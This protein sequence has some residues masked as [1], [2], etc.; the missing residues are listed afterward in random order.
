MTTLITCAHC[1]GSLGR[2][3]RFCAQCGAELLSCTNCGESLLPSD[4]SCPECGTVVEPIAVDDSFAFQTDSE[5]PWNDMVERLRRATLGE[6]EI[7][8]ELGRGGMAAVFLAH[9]ISLARKVAIKVMSPGLLLDDGMIDRFR[10]EA[11]TIAH[12]HH[13]H[14]VSVYSVRQEG[15]LYFFVMQYVEG[16]S[17]EQVIHQGGKLPLP[18][19]RSV[20][21]QVGS[22]LTYAH[23]SRV[24]HRDIKPANILIDGDGN[25]VVTDFGIAKAAESPSRTLTGALVGTPAYMSPEQCRGTE[26]S[27]AS[28]QYSL[29]AVA[30]EML[31]G[32][33]P[34]SGSTF[35]VMQAH[36]ERPPIPLRVLA[37]DC[38]PEL[39]SVIL[40]M[41]AKDPADRFPRIVDA[42]AA[43]GAVPLAEDDPLRAEL[44]RLAAAAGPATHAADTTP[45][46]AVG[47]S[48]PSSAGNASTDS[49]VGGITI[50]PPPLGLEVGDTFA[51]VATVR[52]SHGTVLPPNAVTWSC[53]SPDVLRFEQGGGEAIAVGAGSTLLT[54]ACKDVRAVIR[55]DVALPTADEIVITPIDHAVGVGDEIRLETLVRDKRGQ[56]VTRTV[57]WQSDDSTTAAVD[58]DGNLVALAPGLARITATLDHARASAVIPVVPARVAAIHVAGR[59][60]T[61]AAGR[62]FDVVAT[63]V[64]RWGSPLPGRRVRWSSSDARVAVATAEGRVRAVHPGSVVL[65]A[66]CEGVSESVRVSVGDALA[67]EPAGTAEPA[68]AEPRRIKLRSVRRRR[69]EK[70]LVIALGGVLAGAALWYRSQTRPERAPLDST[71]TVSAAVPEHAASADT[72]R[73]DTV[74]PAVVVSA[75]APLHPRRRP[76]APLPPPAPPESATVS[77]APSDSVAVADSA[78]SP[79]LVSDTIPP[80]RSEEVTEPNRGP[81]PM[82]SGASSPVIVEPEHPPVADPVHERERAEAR[83]LAGVEQCYA[84]VQSKD[85][86]RIA[87]LYK[88]DTRDDKD[89]L[90]KLTRILRTREWSAE[91][92]KRADGLRQLGLETAAMEFS[93]RLSWKDAFGG[94]LSSQ[95]VF[96][97]EFSRSGDRW[98]MA[99]CRIIGSPRL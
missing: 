54:A 20:M 94:H 59:P 63:P 13:P 92:G 38:P 57:T 45:I 43:L 14:I 32:S 85:V 74:A 10:H 11:I 5:S 93:V 49:P 82:S 72:G 78:I 34:F 83:I 21:Y 65:T 33:P 27:G 70:I 77:T 80:A 41:L 58:S 84:A 87:E 29:G 25:V 15:G 64:D 95:P 97:A 19:V 8:R 51:L 96:R 61:V 50:L 67:P 37:A 2:G 23:R 24:I 12:L 4:P 66:S 44:I 3:D 40:R 90:R 31:T 68:T 89:K 47:W 17:L 62:S 73:I 91:V 76:V 6:F 46:S 36:V 28:D 75:S 9:E 22:A 48:L 88:A 69:R 99:S 53:D 86:A 26:V 81:G 16:R 42:I 7:G 71:P 98:D 35:T 56:P 79:T 52:G 55:V 39:E 60:A 1:G 30:Y 18:I